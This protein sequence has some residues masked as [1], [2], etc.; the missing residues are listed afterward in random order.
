MKNII[1]SEEQFDFTRFHAIRDRSLGRLSW[2]LKRHLDRIIEPLLH[3]KGHHDFKLSSLAVMANLEENGVTN[4]ELAKKANVTKQAM[5]KVVSD[6][7]KSGYIYTQPHESDARSNI[8]FLDERGKQLF[9]DLKDIVNQVRQR[10]DAAIGHERI[11]AM[12]SS[13]YDLLAVL[14]LE[15]EE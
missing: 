10:F 4:N 13:M 15:N 8:I 5:S 6:L 14:D 12:I 1:N 9:I 3:A 7:E 11:E 2:R